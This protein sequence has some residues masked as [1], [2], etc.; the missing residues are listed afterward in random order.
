MARRN[1]LVERQD[2]RLVKQSLREQGGRVN[3]L[4]YADT[5]NTR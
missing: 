5:S 2:A 3:S 1:L 4:R